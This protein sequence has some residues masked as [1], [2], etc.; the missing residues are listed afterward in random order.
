[1]AA[2]RKTNVALC[3]ALLA[4][5]AVYAQTRYP[6]CSGAPKYSELPRP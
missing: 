1:M 6:F 2:V 4:C 3:L 5:P